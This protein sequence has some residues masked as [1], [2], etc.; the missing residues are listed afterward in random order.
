MRPIP[1][2]K[3]GVYVHHE[4][5]HYIATGLVSHHETGELFVVYL[6]PQRETMEVMEYDTPGKESWCDIVESTNAPG[7]SVTE[8][9]RRFSWI[10]Y[11]L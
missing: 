5:G 4:G 6:C 2:F 8:M 11:A 7:R 9:V 1:I 3:P 10:R